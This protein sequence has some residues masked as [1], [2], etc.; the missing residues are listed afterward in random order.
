M[1]RNGLNSQPAYRAHFCVDGKKIVIFSVDG[2]KASDDDMTKVHD[3]CANSLFTVGKKPQMVIADSHYGRIEA[4]KYFQDQD[5][6]TCIP[7]R[8][9]D[10]SEGRFRNTD[11]KVIEDGVEMG[12]PAGHGVHRQTSNLYRLQF[13]WP[14]HLC[15]SCPLKE[16]CTQSVH[17]RIVSFYKG[18][19]FTNAE[20]L[21]RSQNGRNLLRARKIIGEGVLGEAKN[22]HSSCR[23]NL[24]RSRQYP[25]RFN[26]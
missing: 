23:C 10:H 7:P 13:H 6:Q 16:R 21:V 20:A 2:S 4:L 9:H 22:F 18:Q 24:F 17:G 26:P 8:I 25:P 19:Y 14:Q 12:C 5:I 3:L 1:S 11:F 15:G